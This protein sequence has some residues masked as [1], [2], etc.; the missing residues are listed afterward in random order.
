VEV[1]GATVTAHAARIAT[2][3]AWAYDLP[4]NQVMAGDSTG[5]ALLRDI[6]Y[7]IVAKADGSVGIDRLKQMFQ[8]LLADRFK[9]SAHREQREMQGYALVVD[10]NGP[11]FKESQGEGDASQQMASKLT[12]H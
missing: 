6:R 9:V 11:K 12:R 7:D 3:V 10:R 8:T 5:S 4:A 1:K 2:C